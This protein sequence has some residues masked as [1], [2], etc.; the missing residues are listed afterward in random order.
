MIPSWGYPPQKRPDPGR[1]GPSAVCACKRGIDAPEA[2]PRC[3]NLNGNSAMRETEASFWMVQNT[4]AERGRCG[5]PP[6]AL[7][8]GLVM[9][10]GPVRAG[11]DDDEDDKTF[12]EKII[13]GIM[14]RH[15]RHQ[16]GKPGHR[17]SRA[18]A[19]GGAAQ[20]RPA[21]AGRYR[22]RGEGAELAEGSRRAAPQGRDRGPQEGQQG[23]ARSGP[24][25]DA[26]RTRGGQDRRPPRAPATIRSSP[27]IRTTTRS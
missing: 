7:G 16:H 12:E 19:A 23:S 15:R 18:L 2:G 5:S 17:V 21:A 3:G 22:G 27:A 6:I 1:Y 13:E 10:A 8:V 4:L 24:H 26:E 11:D 14:A 9:A 25:P 20:A